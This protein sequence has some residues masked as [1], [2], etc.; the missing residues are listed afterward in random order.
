MDGWS[1]RLSDDTAHARHKMALGKLG[2]KRRRDEQRIDDTKRRRTGDESQ[3]AGSR[4]PADPPTRGGDA[5]GSSG[6]SNAESRTGWEQRLLRRLARRPR[7]ARSKERK[8]LRKIKAWLVDPTR[9]GVPWSRLWKYFRPLRILGTEEYE[10]TKIQFDF[11]MG[12]VA[13]LCEEE[14]LLKRARD[15]I[16]FR[17]LVD[18]FCL[19]LPHNW[20]PVYKAV[21]FWFGQVEADR[22]TLRKVP[23]AVKRYLHRMVLDELEELSGPGEVSTSAGEESP[24]GVASEPEDQDTAEQERTSNGED[25]GGDPEEDE[26]SEECG[27]SREEAQEQSES[28]DSHSDSGGH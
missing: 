11:L 17:R 7:G 21:N 9:S 28:E 15:F 4:S 3:E 25:S 20:T 1:G 6:M 19:D 23:E 12:H 2:G 10:G 27:S 16:I 14:G 26:S 8:R 18:R 22:A 24:A 5:E 13:E